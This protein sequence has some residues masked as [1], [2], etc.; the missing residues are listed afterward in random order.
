MPKSMKLSFGEKI[1]HIKNDL[2]LKNI[3]EDQIKQ[4]IDVRK[5]KAIEKY[6]NRDRVGILISMENPDPLE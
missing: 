4:E 5:Q 1:P 6:G 2:K 3:R